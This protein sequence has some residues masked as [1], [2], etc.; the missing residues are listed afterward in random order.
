M[1]ELAAIFVR[2]LLSTRGGGKTAGNVRTCEPRCESLFII[3]VQATRA[4]LECGKR[5]QPE[6]VG[7]L[8]SASDNR[9]AVYSFLARVYRVE[10]TKETLKE[11]AEKR[12]LWVKLAEDTDV[13][14]TDVSEGFGALA[15]FATSLDTANLDDSRLQLAVEY[16]GLFLGVWQLPPHPSESVYTSSEHMIMQKA[17]DN[18]VKIY[19]SMGLNK[20]DEFR[21]PED[22]IAIELR[23]MAYLSG[24]TGDAL[25]SNDLVGAQK[26]LEVQRDFLKEHL[27]KWVPKLAAD[28]LK[29]AQREFYKAIAK[30]TEGYVRIDGDVVLEMLESL[31]LPSNSGAD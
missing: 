25:K 11:I 21:E 12:D 18:V 15:Q 4:L 22:H 7:E 27:S 8:V 28:I 10:L 3:N 17:R 2:R 16:A 31:P 29:G 5:M 13:R 20:V 1:F 24:K 6:I 9:Q 19:K 30:I 14:G 23:F 26:Y